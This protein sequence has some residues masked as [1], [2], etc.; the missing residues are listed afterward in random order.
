M[1]RS[2]AEVH[3][4]GIRRTARAA[5]R[6]ARSAEGDTASVFNIAPRSVG[7]VPGGGGGAE[8]SVGD[9]RKRKGKGK[10]TGL[11]LL[12]AGLLRRGLLLWGGLDLVNL[13]R[14][15]VLDQVSLLHAALEALEELAL[16]VSGIE[17][18]ALGDKG[19]L[20]GRE[21]RTSA[22]A[23]AGDRLD[24]SFLGGHI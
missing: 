23:E 8:A 11:T 22:L 16:L 14:A 20:D 2:N 24:D 12:L 7:E 15:L 9:P 10:Q 17:V 3:G 18:P 13:V 19:L 4:R 5:E 21:R 6:E 1:R